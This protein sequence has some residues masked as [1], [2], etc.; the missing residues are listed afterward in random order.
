MV[1][2]DAAE[3]LT[4]MLDDAG[5]LFLNQTEDTTRI[6]LKFAERYV[7]G[8]RDALI[9]ASFVNPSV[10]EFQTFDKELIRL[11]RVEHGRRSLIIHSA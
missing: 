9:L 4:E 8:G 2:A 1:L 6:C 3:A 5:V 11:R 10:A 7:P